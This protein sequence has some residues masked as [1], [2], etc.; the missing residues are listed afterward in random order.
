MWTLLDISISLFSIHMQMELALIFF[1]WHS[2]Q[3]PALRTA[4]TS[5]L[6]CGSYDCRLRLCKTGLLLS[7]RLGMEELGIGVNGDCTC[8]ASLT[9]ASGKCE[10]PTFKFLSLDWK[11]S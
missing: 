3:A 8:A 10:Y 2:L 4:A 1:W 9:V 5:D 7:P 6:L 11:E